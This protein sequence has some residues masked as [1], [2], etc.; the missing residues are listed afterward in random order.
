MQPYM[1]D[2]ARSE[3]C[4]YLNIWAPEGKGPFPVFVWIH[5]GGGFSSGMAAAPMFDGTEFARAGIVCVT[6]AYRLGI[7]GFADLE[8]LLGRTYAGTGNNGLRDL[9]A[10]LEWVQENIAALGGDPSRVTVG[11]ES[12]GAKLTDILMGVPVAEPLFH[13]MISESGG[14][15]RVLLHANAI[16]VGQGF[17]AEWSGSGAHAMSELLTADAGALIEAQERFLKKWPQHFPLRPEI[18]GS[19]MTKLPIEQIT[20]GSTR[21]KRLLIGTNRDE[22]A[23]FIGAHPAKDASMAN[24]GNISVERFHGGV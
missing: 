17:G 4:L 19:L 10:G 7:F 18:D 24:L 20:E 3:D 5:G 22:S 13:Q 15:E 14:A 11:G 1:E 21:H 23:A 2:A 12:A 16:A 8:P 6:V 9:M